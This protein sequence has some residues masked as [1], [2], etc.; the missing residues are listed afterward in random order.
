METSR[1]AGHEQAMAA[2]SDQEVSVSWRSWTSSRGGVSTRLAMAGTA[3]AAIGVPTRPS[4]LATRRAR[5]R[6][7]KPRRPAKTRV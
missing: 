1:A 7:P 2:L 3:K 4:I 5:V 6:S